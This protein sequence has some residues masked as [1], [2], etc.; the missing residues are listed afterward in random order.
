MSLSQNDR[1]MLKNM[2]EACEEKFGAVDVDS[3]ICEM[4]C[5][6]CSG[7]CDGHGMSVWTTC[8]VK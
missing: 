5:T 4:G 2:L 3:I 7:G 1:E 6:Q 8:D